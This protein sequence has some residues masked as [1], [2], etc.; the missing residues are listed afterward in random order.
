M[1]KAVSNLLILEPIP[2]CLLDPE[3]YDDVP[4]HQDARQ[5]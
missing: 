4:E 2:T 3:E 5:L 1:W